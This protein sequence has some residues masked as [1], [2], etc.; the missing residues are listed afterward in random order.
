MEVDGSEPSSNCFTGNCFC[1]NVQ[2]K[3]DGEPQ[4]ASYCHCS[5]CRRLSGA[6]FTAQAVFRSPSVEVNVVDGSLQE[7][8]SSKD[9]IRKRCPKCFSPVVASLF[10]G[11][12]SAVPLS[13]FPWK[14]GLVPEALKPQHH[15]YYAQRLMDIDDGLPK[16]EARHNGK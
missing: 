2:V 15:I 8:N 3:I 4:T 13:L 7:F 11:K 16:Y 14:E 1:E 5:N 10:K 12:L 9:V 6:P